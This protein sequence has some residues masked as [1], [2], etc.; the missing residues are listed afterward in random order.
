MGSR[1]PIMLLVIA[2]N[3]CQV[4]DIYPIRASD[5]VILQE[6]GR[7][8]PLARLLT[9]PTLD[10]KFLL[11]ACLER[12]ETKLRAVPDILGVRF[13]QY[14]D[15]AGEGSEDEE[16]VWAMLYAVPCSVLCYALCGAMR[17]AMLAMLCSMLCD[18]LCYPMLYALLYAMLCSRLRYALCYAI[19]S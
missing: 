18:A 2:R 6:F 1:A 16:L 12:V 14:R 9:A 7:G 5:V 8:G 11:V 13:P 15:S 19:V 4:G 3:I 17:Y 10:M